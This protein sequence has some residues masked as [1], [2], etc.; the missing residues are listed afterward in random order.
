MGI[1]DYKQTR[2]RLRF[3]RLS[4]ENFTIITCHCNV[5]PTVNHTMF[6]FQLLRNLTSDDYAEYTRS[7]ITDDQTQNTSYY[8]PDFED[9][10]DHGTAH[11]SIFAAD[12]AAVAITATINLL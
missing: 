11:A 9:F 8:E 1:S 7:R 12:G 5:G 2:L 4:E 6:L 3:I 10:T